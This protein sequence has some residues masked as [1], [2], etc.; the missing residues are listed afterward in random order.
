M[1]TTTKRHKSPALTLPQKRYLCD[2]MTATYLGSESFRQQLDAA[3]PHHTHSLH[4][5]RHLNELKGI[6]LGIASRIREITQ[7]SLVVRRVLAV[8]LVLAFVSLVQ[9]LYPRDRTLPLARLQTQGFVGFS[10]QQ[11]VLA[12]FQDFDSRTVTIH[13]H[14]KTITSSYRDLGVTLQPDQTMD[15]LSGYSFQQRLIPFSIFLVGNKSHQISRQLNESQLKLFVSDTVRQ[16]N[17]KPVNAEVTRTGT[18]LTVS[19]SEEGYEYNYDELKSQMLRSDLRANGQIVFSP[20]ILYPDITTDAATT[21]ATKMQARILN[22]IT[23][24][25]EGQTMVVQPETIA[26]WLVIKPDYV[27]KTVNLSFD[28]AR[29]AESIRPYIA[30]IDV[31]Y[32][33]HVNTLLNGMPAGRREG[34]VGKRLE[35]AE[36][37]DKVA[38]ATAPATSTIEAPITTLQP[39][40]TT[41]RTYTRDSAGLQ[42]LINY[43][44]QNHRG[45]FSIDVRSLNG[46]IEANS[47][48]Y[49]LFP[50]V[51]IYRIYISHMIYGRI[52]GKSLSGQTMTSA[53]YNVDVCLDK[54]MRESHDPCTEALGTLVGWG[55]ADQLLTTQG[56]ETTTLAQGAGLTSANDATDWLTKLLASNITTGAQASTLTNMLSKSSIRS[57]IPAGSRGMN[58]ANKAGSYGR[59]VHDV[60]IVYH[61]SGAYALSVLSE[62]SNF[63]AIADLTQE[64]NKVFSQ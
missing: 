48:P 57:G 60:G 21:E 14:D 51:G 64:I 45:S 6:D 43:W 25:G 50:S 26:S 7:E 10:T 54:M 52:N 39:A 35:F 42:N 1:K 53:G 58:V 3:Y 23:I 41:Q 36:L 59:Y 55:A 22:P 28:K 63:A 40:E 46:R 47:N 5:R 2:V 33:A 30:Q 56:F 19:A 9:V 20:T 37:V 17:K 44:T 24:S 49:R 38:A 11:A 4:L 61:P 27:G 13:T 8:F 62:G 16:V 29:V 32:V 31:P 34:T 15:Q 18:K 12:G